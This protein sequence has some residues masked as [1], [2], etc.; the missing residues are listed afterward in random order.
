MEIVLLGTGAALPTQ[1]RW[2]SAM[3]VIREDEILLFDCGEGAQIQ[4]QKAQ[5]KPGK[6]THIFI[7]HFHGDHFYG[8]I[9]LLTSLELGGREKPLSIYGPHGLAEYLEF[10]QKLSHFTLGNEIEINE[11][12][13]GKKQTV[14]DFGDYVISALPLEHR[15]L[16]FGFRLE[17]KPRPGKFD[18][19]KA[20]ELG[21]ADGP[22]RGRLQ[23]GESIVLPNGQEIKPEQVLG[24]ERPGK[25]VTIC[26]DS[27]PCNN[28]VALARN[29]DLLIHEATFDESRKERADTTRHSTFAQAAEVAAEA[30]AQKLLLT[31]ISARYEKT[32]EAE[33]LAQATKIF[34]NTILGHDLMRFQI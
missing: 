11:I 12:E 18:L 30:G 15:I 6:L 34:P 17:E 31:H 28:S 20:D 13:D 3:A 21:I 9:G 10:M 25:T 4:F 24:P 32:E 1:S 8:L 23:K 14:W 7:S 19:A 27:R 2:P 16:V 29:A 33:L 5:L 26:L 22:M